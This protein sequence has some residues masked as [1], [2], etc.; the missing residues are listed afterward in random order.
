MCTD[1]HVC[2]FTRS[3]SKVFVPFFFVRQHRV[4]VTLKAQCVDVGGTACELRRVNVTL[5]Q[6]T[7]AQ[8]GRRL[9]FREQIVAFN[10]KIR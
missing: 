8:C 1:V 6:S 9:T 10:V 3:S 7:S 2:L 4:F 5:N